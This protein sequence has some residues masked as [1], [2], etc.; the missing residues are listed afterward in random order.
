MY[1]RPFIV[2]RTR[3]ENR[4][5][6]V[7]DARSR[8]ARTL[9]GTRLTEIRAN[10]ARRRKWVAAQGTFSKSRAARRRLREIPRKTFARFA[11]LRN[12]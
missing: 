7:A 4:L 1:A 9:C 5:T 8:I 12:G 6:A 3:F 11:E 2:P 10:T